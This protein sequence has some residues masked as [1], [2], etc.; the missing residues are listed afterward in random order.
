M[1]SDRF[2]AAWRRGYVARLKDVVAARRPGELELMP[3]EDTVAALGHQG[4]IDLGH[5]DVPVADIVGTIARRGDFDRQFRPRNRALRHRWDALADITTT[6]PVRLVRLG[7]LYFVEDGHHRVA[8]ARARGLDG[9]RAHVRK[10]CTIS[11]ATRCLTVADLPVKAAERVFLERVP[12][13]DDVRWGLWLDHP[14][15]WLKLADAAEAWGFRNRLHDRVRLA[16]TWWDQEVRPVVAGLALRGIEPYDVRAYHR[17]LQHRESLGVTCFDD[18]VV[19]DIRR[20]LIGDYT[21]PEWHG[22]V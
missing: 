17:A 7:Q 14:A 18:A 9:V 21:G 5:Q 3:L 22:M 10:I 8:L 4:E 11:C 15:D 1:G 13:P 20:R 2:D 16:E 6:E 19:A 12:L